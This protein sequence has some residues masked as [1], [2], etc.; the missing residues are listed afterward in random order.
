[1]LC[2]MAYTSFFQL[3]IRDFLKRSLRFTQ[4]NQF[5]IDQK[6]S[7]PLLDF[8]GSSRS[9]QVVDFLPRNHPGNGRDSL[10]WRLKVP[11]VFLQRGIV[12]GIYSSLGCRESL[13]YGSDEN[14]LPL[15]LLLGNKKRHTTI[16]Q[17]KDEQPIHT[18]TI[19]LVPTGSTNDSYRDY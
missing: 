1:M 17:Q 7:I 2:L 16:D 6:K 15:V 8:S 5:L 9:T 18:F 4:T 12:H 10:H 13:K 14:H 11:V 3:N 19:L